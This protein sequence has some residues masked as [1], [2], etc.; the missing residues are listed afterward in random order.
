MQT[1]V[2]CSEFGF[3]ITNLVA[4]PSPGIDDLAPSEYLDGWHHSRTED[5]R[6]IARGSLRSSV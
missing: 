4:R 2:A 3:G 6:S 5:S 1:T